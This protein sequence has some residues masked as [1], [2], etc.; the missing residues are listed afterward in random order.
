MQ[1][2]ETFET[3]FV[4]EDEAADD[5]RSRQRAA[6]EE[7]VAS[8]V[9]RAV[10]ARMT[11][12]I[13][14]IWQEDDEQ[15]NGLEW[16]DTPANQ[17]PSAKSQSRSQAARPNAQRSR[18]YVNITKP[19]TDVGV[20]R[21]QELLVPHDDKPW[22]IE[23]TPVPEVDAAI[24]ADD[25]TP[26]ATAD[27]GQV[28]RV[29]AAKALASDLLKRSEKMAK[30]IDDWFVEG[31][32]LTEWRKVIRAAGRI[33]TGV[34][35]GPFPTIRKDRKW[36]GGKVTQLERLCPTSKAISAWDFF[37]DPSCGENFR[38]GAFC[39]ERDYLTGR[40]VRNL[41]RLP[42]YD[43]QAIAEI[44]KEGPR[45]G[46]RYDDRYQ[47]EK[48]GQVITFDSETFET[49]YYYGDIPPQT[50]VAG[51][52]TIAGLI[53]SEVPEELAQQID[54]AL[55]LI[56]VPVV[57]TVINDRIVRICTNP[58]ETG[59]FP[60][61]LFVWEPVEGQP[62]GRG[63]PRQMAPAQKML[64]A[65]TRAMLE[66]AGMSAG[67]QVLM[68]RT[69]ITPANGRYEITGRKLWFMSDEGAADEK[70]VDGR[71]LFQV[72]NVPSAQK[73]LQAIIQY[74]LEMAD[75]LTNLPLMM[76]GDQGSAPDTVGGMAMLEANAI[77]PLKV[78]AKA[79]DDDLVVPHL[80]RYYSWGMQDPQVPDDAKGDMQVKA[81]GASALILRDIYAQ[82]LPQLL[83]MVKDPAF[84][85]DP[86]KYLDELL[87]S[88]KLNPEVLKLSAEQ[89][90]AQEEA[91]AQNPPVDP[92]VE[93]ANVLAS[94]RD[95]AQKAELAD[96][97]QEREFK[98]AEAAM[99]R[100]L[101]QLLADVEF[102]VQ[103]MEFAGQ[104]EI[105][106]EQLRAM[107]ATKSMDIKN[108]RELFVAE[109]ALKL[110][111]ANET[112]EGV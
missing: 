14:D 9:R 52:W 21:V 96:R 34:L 103:S 74:A 89:V 87:R 16:D 11:S 24:E 25:Q 19:K 39:V 55:E 75:Q 45:S 110:D 61:D 10:D 68:H 76:Q 18:I 102:Q 97:Q 72:V 105:T 41:A 88:N 111:P 29:D 30:H 8:R 71:F 40:S 62:W 33:G 94:Q 56:T 70:P 112:H 79:Y 49:F 86:V 28:P 17:V 109:R 77:S 107:L 64:N 57:V 51:G 4:E 65:A 80:S 44:L 92:K 59:E 48:R 1:Q 20:A 108:Q 82:I 90:Q 6:L 42:D 81:R 13:E 91:M 85:L 67:P 26:V 104:K 69:R 54:L 47:R 5:E 36:Q 101:Q 2:K 43:A 99:D 98:A 100:Q 31:R 37:P 38:E 22:A 93:A 58:L 60:F 73:E 83:P 78:K 32:V 53:D 84:K 106:F 66:N 95:A 50:L 46:G 7:L 23:P 27:G 3:A 15:Y 12:G 35:K 63:I